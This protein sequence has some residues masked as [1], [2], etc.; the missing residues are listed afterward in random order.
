MGNIIC[1]ILYKAYA[2]KSPIKNLYIKRSIINIIMKIEGG[3]VYS[4]TLRKIFKEYH[5]V[6]IGMYTFGG[7]FNPGQIDKHTIIGRYSSIARTAWV[8]NR[9]HPIDRKSS[10]ALFFNPIFGFTEKDY[11]EYTPLTIGND[12][13]IGHNACVMPHVRN[14]GDGAIV[15][16][17]AIVNKDVPPYAIVVGNPARVV[18]YRFSKKVIDELLSSKWWEK[19][20]EEIMPNIQEYQRTYEEQ[21]SHPLDENM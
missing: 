15:A 19:T 17:G 21:V 5:N 3:E 12:V 2:I 11:I 18:R 7:C 13:W 10:C 20:I 16:A 8:G 1:T 9:N 4:K 6:D 14:I